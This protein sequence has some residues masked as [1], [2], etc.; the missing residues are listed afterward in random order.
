[1]R[2]AYNKDIWRAIWKGKKRFFSIMLITILGVGMFSGLKAACVDLRHS[3]DDFLDQ[4]NLYDICVL[5]TLGLTEEDVE[6]LSQVEGIAYA[7]GTYSETVHTRVGEKNQSASVKTIS[8]S[9]LNQPYLVDGTLPENPNEIAVTSKFL[10]ETGCEIDFT[11]RLLKKLGCN[12]NLIRIFWKCTI[13]KI[14]LI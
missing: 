9:G 14:R 12:C 1:M 11:S 5:S 10:E 3:A 2:K 7:E 6:A 8:A 4:Q 13:H